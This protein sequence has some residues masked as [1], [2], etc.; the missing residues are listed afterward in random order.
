VGRLD[1]AMTAARREPAGLCEM[2]PPGTLQSFDGG[3]YPRFRDQF[4]HPND[5][6]K[7][8]PNIDA[9]RDSPSPELRSLS[10]GGAWRRP[11]GN[12]TSRRKR[13]EVK[14]DSC[15]DSTQRHHAPG[16]R[17]FPRR[18]IEARQRLQGL[19][20]GNRPHGGDASC[21]IEVL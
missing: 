18:M 10:S 6:Q 3:K 1:E 13:R 14:W 20:D 7:Q 12:P 2:G 9:C 4:V 21:A 17:R 16:G 11:V 19:V 5:L 15:A 8:F